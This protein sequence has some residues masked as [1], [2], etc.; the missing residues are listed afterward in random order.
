MLMHLVAFCRPFLLLHENGTE[1]I[2]I[3]INNENDV[4]SCVSLKK[5]KKR[6]R[7]MLCGYQ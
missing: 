4:Q 1:T 3:N 2:G 7:R 5:D 6:S